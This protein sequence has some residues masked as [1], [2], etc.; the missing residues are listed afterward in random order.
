MTSFKNWSSDKHIK[1]SVFI[2]I[3]PLAGGAGYTVI[4]KLFKKL[5]KS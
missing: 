2:A 1:S 3:P 5:L 4:L